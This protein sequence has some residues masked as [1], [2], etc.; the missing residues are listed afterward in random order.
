MLNASL[1]IEPDQKP[2][3]RAA[4]AANKRLST[5][6]GASIYDGEFFEIIMREG[7]TLIVR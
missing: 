1:K 3:E 7:D 5:D 6:A 4:A 2:F